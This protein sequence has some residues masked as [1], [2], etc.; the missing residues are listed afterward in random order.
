MVYKYYIHQIKTTGFKDSKYEAIALVLQLF[1]MAA[2][3]IRNGA[4]VTGL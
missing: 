4:S 3:I 2:H 1:L